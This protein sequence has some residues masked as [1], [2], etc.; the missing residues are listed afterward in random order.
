ME[1]SNSIFENNAQMT[2]PRATRHQLVNKGITTFAD[3][4]EFDKPTFQ[5]ISDNLCRP[6]GRIPDPNYV[7]PNPLPLPVS[8]VLT[9]A[10]PP[11]IFGA[12]THASHTHTPPSALQEVIATEIAVAFGRQHVYKLVDVLSLPKADLS[13]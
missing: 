8:Q 1:S 6:G 5:Q 4:G 9:I 13:G 12:K 2:M 11:F 10:T 7:P 3:V